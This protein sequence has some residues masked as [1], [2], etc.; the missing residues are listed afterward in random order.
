MFSSFGRTMEHYADK[1]GQKNFFVET[2]MLQ[3]LLASV[4]VLIQRICRAR[5]RL[6]SE[7]QDKISISN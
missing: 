7:V 2:P 4:P 1:M 6:S 5:N 3:A